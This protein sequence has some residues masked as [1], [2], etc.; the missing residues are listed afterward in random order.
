[1]IERLQKYLADCGVAS[2]R[3]SEEIISDGRV[4]VNG[5]TVLKVVPVDTDKDIVCVDGKKVTP[6]KKKIYI[7]LNKPEG[8]IT[9]VHDQFDRKTVMDIV[10]IKERI[11]PVGRLDYD[12]SGLIILT[13]DGV[14]ANKIMHPSKQVNKVYIAKIKGIPSDEEIK[15]FK[16]GI[17]IDGIK[18]SNANFKVLE[19]GNGNS[20]VEI[21]IHEGRNRQ[22][23]KMCSSIGHDV[24]KLKRISIGE[25]KL[26]NLKEGSFRQMNSDEISYLKSL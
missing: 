25:V 2:R 14:C 17:I 11:F 24:I 26:G 13:N 22:V 3:K 12:T 21:T 10:K 4:S 19:K 8:V 1:M 23:R 7:L 9:S 18:T 20:T 5:N 15:N 6:E 16:N